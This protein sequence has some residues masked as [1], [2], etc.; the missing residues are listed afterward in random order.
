MLWGN[1]Q[2]R[3]PDLYLLVVAGVLFQGSGN[4]G[5][6]TDTGTERVAGTETV[7]AT[8]GDTALAQAMAEFQEYAQSAQRLVLATQLLGSSRLRRDRLAR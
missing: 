1:V 5:T 3:S 6:G 8:R 7:P 4:G 2:K